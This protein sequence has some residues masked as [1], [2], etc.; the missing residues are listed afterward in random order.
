MEGVIA[1]HEQPK[2]GASPVRYEEL[3]PTGFM[4]QLGANLR[5][6]FTI[7]NRAPGGMAAQYGWGPVPAAGHALLAC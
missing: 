6:N 7:Y 1:G 2:E 4:G 5:R 3:L